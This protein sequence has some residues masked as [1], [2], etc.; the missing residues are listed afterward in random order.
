[1]VSTE[2]NEP[3]T[4]NEPDSTK[5]DVLLELKK[6]SS[7]AVNIDTV[8]ESEE[9]FMFDYEAI[10][11]EVRK[12]I[13]KYG[14]LGKA[15]IKE[16]MVKHKHGESDEEEEEDEEEEMV[17]EADIITGNHIITE[18]GRRHIAIVT[19]TRSDNIKFTK[20]VPVVM[21]GSNEGPFV[22]LHVSLFNEDNNDDINIEEFQDTI[23]SIDQHLER[24]QSFKR[25][26]DVSL[27][28]FYIVFSF[29]IP[30]I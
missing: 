27:F 28:L 8:E 10:P 17:D 12:L 3:N 4:K 19:T 15:E 26:A 29:L 9:T 16:L 22:D 24:F 11:S 6:M 7:T 1:M 2:N 13:D 25:N 23:H 20:L 30:R 18:K 21:E 14:D 5:E